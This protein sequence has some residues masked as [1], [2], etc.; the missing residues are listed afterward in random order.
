MIAP[1]I[2][3]LGSVEAPPP[4]GN[5]SFTFAQRFDQSISGSGATTNFVLSQTTIAGS[6]LVFA[7]VPIGAV[8]DRSSTLTVTD[9]AGSSW[10]LIQSSVASNDRASLIFSA[11]TT[12]AVTTI[13]VK[14][15][16]GSMS[17]A[18]EAAFEIA[19][20]PSVLSSDNYAATGDPFFASTAG[21]AAP[22]NAAWV[23]TWGNYGN[24]NLVEMTG[25][26]W[27]T[28][29]MS[30]G[31]QKIYYGINPGSE[32]AYRAEAD[33]ETNGRTFAG[34]LAAFG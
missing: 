18:D 17:S 20:A 34:C 12:A 13:F 23:V 6:R 22:A 15:D 24:T 28:L 4:G 1:V 27:W 31:Q 2:A 9:D 33:T 30:G 19:D 25:A 16:G 26:P 3:G 14:N 7:V 10:S 21:I 29:F 32:T 11:L 8:G 5:P